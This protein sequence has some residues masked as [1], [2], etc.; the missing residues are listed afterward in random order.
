MGFLRL[1]ADFADINQHRGSIAQLTLDIILHVGRFTRAERRK[2]LQSQR[3]TC[4]PIAPSE[5]LH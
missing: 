4:F 2:P 5:T 3:L 1:S